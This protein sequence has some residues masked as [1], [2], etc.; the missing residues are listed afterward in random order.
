[1][2]TTLLLL[3]TFIY[4][5]TVQSQEAL[6][7]SGGDATGSGGTSSYTLG[8]V[9]YTA[10]NTSNG[11]ISQ[12]VQQSFELFTLSNPQL[13]SVNL[14][15]LVYPNPS[16]GYVMLKITDRSLTK[17]SYVLMDIQGQVVSNAKINSLDTQVNLYG[18]SVGTYLLKVNQK[19]SELKTFK[20]IKK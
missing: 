5:F 15:A 6:A 17:L 3:F 4:S 12:G 19:N 14:E 1:M 7:I 8:Q 18:L 2:K 13:T 10:T 11:S 9:F 20:I 16:S